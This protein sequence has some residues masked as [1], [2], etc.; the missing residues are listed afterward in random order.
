MAQNQV[1]L[2]ATKIGEPLIKASR[3]IP[4]PKEGEVL[5][6]VTIAG[7]NPHDAKARDHGLF[8]K[9]HLPAVLG[10]D[11]VGI[12]M[13]LGPDV[14]RF[15]E[16]DHIFGQAGLLGANLGGHFNFGVP[17][18]DTQGLQEYAILETKYS[19][20]VP[21][22]FTDAQMATV[23]TNCVPAAVAFF[24]KTCFGIPAPWDA[25]ASEFDYKGTSL[26]IIGGGSNTGKFGI[27]LAALL[28]I[29]KIIVVAGLKG[30][31]DAKA[32]GAT[33]V[34]DRTLSATDI[35]AE[36]REI[37][38]DN[39][40]YAFDTINKPGDQY[41]GVEA[42]S[43]TE[44]GKLARLIPLGPVDVSRLSSQKPAGFDTLDV[45]GVSTGSPATTIPLW[46]H[47]VGW[48]EEGK[49]KP[50]SFQVI[51]GLDVDAVNKTLDGYSNG[52]VTGQWQVQF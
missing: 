42:L 11:V 29:G 15:K 50:T 8:I 23:P 44:T 33:H 14:T 34:I 40:I 37:V 47:I 38:G 10:A 24:D 49:L 46:E 28:G 51:E 41:V 35:A 30:A 16:G 4:V 25:A 31:A 27:Q 9:D 36:V 13:S 43:N 2:L 19:A 5:I 17:N 32:L 48:V 20:K 22:G 6:K 21:L 52:T 45:L 12:V 39:L 7:L 18:Y 26:L 3:P 1:A